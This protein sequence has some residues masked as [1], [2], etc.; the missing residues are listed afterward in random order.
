MNQLNETKENLPNGNESYMDF[1]L[2]RGSVY[3]LRGKLTDAVI[4]CD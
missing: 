2:Q 1:P 3:R 4:N